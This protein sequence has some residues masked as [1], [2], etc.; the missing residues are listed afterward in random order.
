[1]NNTIPNSLKIH[2]P[3]DRILKSSITKLI[4]KEFVDFN[5]SLIHDIHSGRNNHRH[6]NLPKKLRVETFFPKT[7]NEN[8]QCFATVQEPRQEDNQGP[9]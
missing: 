2:Q 5:N 9:D 7:A 1:M 8:V 6:D 3:Q 4:K